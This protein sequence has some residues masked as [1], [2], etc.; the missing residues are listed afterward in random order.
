MDPGRYG[1]AELYDAVAALVT[2]AGGAVEGA[3]LV[4]LIPEVVLGAVP[5]RRWAELGLSAEATV[6]S[7]LPAP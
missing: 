6:E 4:G 3:E 5:P 7:R 1:P 2:Q